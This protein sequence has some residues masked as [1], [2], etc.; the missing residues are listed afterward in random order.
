MKLWDRLTPRETEVAELLIR[1]KSWVEIAKELGMA[2]RTIKSHA[3]VIYLKAGLLDARR[4]RHIRLAV[5][6]TYERW[7]E[8]DP[9]IPKKAG[10]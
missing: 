5:A 7:P 10:S 4:F 2:T 9:S 8:L 6:L 3:K 1:G